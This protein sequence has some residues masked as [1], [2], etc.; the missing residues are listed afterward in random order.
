MGSRTSTAASPCP[1]E[2]LPSPTSENSLSE[3]SY[4]K[5]HEQFST[6]LNQRTSSTFRKICLLEKEKVEKSCGIAAED[7]AQKYRV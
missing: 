6:H 1:P 4:I 5:E 2:V 7:A 3:V